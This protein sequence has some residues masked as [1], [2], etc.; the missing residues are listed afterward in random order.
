MEQKKETNPAERE[1][2]R[3]LKDKTVGGTHMR[4]LQVAMWKLQ[5]KSTQEVAVLSKYDERTVRRIWAD[6]RAK[7]VERMEPQYTGKN[8]M[9]LSYEAEEEALQQCAAEAN[10]GKY[11]RVA[12]LQERF[13]AITGVHY[14]LHV[15][16]RLLKRHNWRKVA[17][18]GKHPKAA[19]EAACDAAKKL[20]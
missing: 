17:P 16:Y 7:G 19:S 1:I 8:R 5:G 11:L 2:E 10:E 18:R 3:L 14:H 15:F 20:T 4:H 12:E 13:E 9:K 6:Y